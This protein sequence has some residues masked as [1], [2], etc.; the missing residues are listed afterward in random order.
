[1]RT[2]VVSVALS[3]LANSSV[4]ILRVRRRRRRATAN[5]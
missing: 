3:D 1:M 2:K 5:L 4:V